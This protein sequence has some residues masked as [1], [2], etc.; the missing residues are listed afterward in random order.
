MSK[1]QLRLTAGE[2]ARIAFLVARM[3]KRGLADDR[4]F[5]GRVD[6]R[7]LQRKVERIEEQA[8]K[9]AKNGK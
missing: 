6:Q 8:R 4:Q 5:G 2:K 7:D 3:A 9:R 1:E